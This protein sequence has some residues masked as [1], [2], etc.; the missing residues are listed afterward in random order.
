MASEREDY[1]QPVGEG[2]AGMPGGGTGRR[3]EP[4][5]TGIYPAGGTTAPGDATIRTSG[6][7]GHQG[8][9]DDQADAGTSG[10]GSEVT[11]QRE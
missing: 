2:D 11:E 8:Q 7:L 3:E 6:G 9:E 5:H 1:V 10:P 4:G